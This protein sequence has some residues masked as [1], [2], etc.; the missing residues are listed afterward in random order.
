MKK[1]DL[2]LGIFSWFGFI[3]PIQERLK[4]IKEAGFDSTAIWWEDEEG[5]RVVKKE[6]FP[7]LVKDSGLIFENIH[8]PFLN[9]NMLWSEDE[10]LRKT[11]VR[12]HV[13]LI[14]D[15][16]KYEIPIMV[17]HISEG[18]LLKTPNELGIRSIRQI[19][20]EAENNNVK[21]AIENTDNNLFIDYALKNI[22][23]PNL[24][25]CFDTSHNEISDR[26]DINLLKEYRDRLFT[27]HISDN[28]GLKD[29]H[30]IPYQG[31]INW[32]K[33]KNNFPIETYKGHLSMEVFT[34]EEDKNKSAEEFLSKAYKN[35]CKLRSYLMV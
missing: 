20:K 21:I 1:E 6:E 17:M 34:K 29:R 35:V 16:A 14:E 31:N 7:K 4:L 5:D 19:I 28:D 9:C 33:M 24:G 10:D 25:F 13:Q 15:C 27:L 23:S 26:N 3:M 18:F 11:T 2:K 22:H 32:A 12:K 8:A 30:W